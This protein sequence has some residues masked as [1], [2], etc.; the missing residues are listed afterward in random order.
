M[1]VGSTDTQVSSLGNATSTDY[2]L[3]L[4]GDLAQ[5]EQ[6]SGAQRNTTNAAQEAQANGAANAA[7]SA[8]M[9]DA[10]R[11]Q[12]DLARQAAFTQASVKLSGTLNQMMGAA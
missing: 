11:L 12:E 1:P 2:Q 6:F 10:T 5:G 8:I 4:T 9:D 3:D 7:N